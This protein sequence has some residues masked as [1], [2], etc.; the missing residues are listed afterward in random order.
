MFIFSVQ[1]E[2]CRLKPVPSY[3]HLNVNGNVQLESKVA[4]L[5][6]V[7]DLRLIVEHWK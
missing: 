5:T 3:L 6:S 4:F 1:I 2:C 7:D